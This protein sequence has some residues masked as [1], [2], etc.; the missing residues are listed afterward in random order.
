MKSKEA[1]SVPGFP[2]ARAPQYNRE[3]G[4]A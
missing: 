1:D 3:R 4:R 2:W